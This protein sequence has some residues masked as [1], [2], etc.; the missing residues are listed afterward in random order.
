MVCARPARG[1]GAG[2][3]GGGQ[4][5]VARG[6]GESAVGRAD[7]VRRGDGGPFR[8][9]PGWTRARTWPLAGPAVGLVRGPPRRPLH[10]HGDPARTA[11]GRGD[12]AGTFRRGPDGRSAAARSV[13]ISR[14]ALA[15]RIPGPAPRRS[16]R[17]GRRLPA[18]ARLTAAA[19]KARPCGYCL[20]SAVPP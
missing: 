19:P 3:T 12:H 14:R 17:G 8:P 9:G 10:L 13:R 16:A 15:H 18:P 20:T 2:G 1:N 11:D 7:L 6:G 4:C 5:P